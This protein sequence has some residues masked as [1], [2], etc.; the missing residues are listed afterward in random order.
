MVHG[1]ASTQS[2]SLAQQKP[3]GTDPQVPPGKQTASEQGSPPVQ[4][5][6]TSQQLG[7]GSFLDRDSKFSDAVHGAMMSIGTKPVKTS[8]RSPW[9]NGTAERWI[10][11]CRRDVL[12]HVV[13]LGERHLLRLV[14]E[15]VAYHHDDRTHLG[16]D[17]DTPIPRAVTPKPSADAEVVALPRIGGLHHRYEWRDAA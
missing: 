13:V 5:S 12:D 6:S 9:Q 15:Y 3:L 7:E 17:K 8:F 16:L 11:S 2:A 4:S 10:G 14:K 1:L